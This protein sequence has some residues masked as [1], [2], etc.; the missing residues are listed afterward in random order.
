MAAGFVLSKMQTA[1]QIS[2]APTF[3]GKASSFLDYEP[4]VILRNGS[5][6][7]PLDK[8]PTL[9]ISHMDPAARQVCLFSGGDTL[10]EGGDAMLVV[11]VLRDY[12]QPDAVDRVSAQAE[13]Y[14]SYVRT[15]QTIEKFLMEFGILR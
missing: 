15:D 5:T 7:F 11:Q 6:D 8:R 13:R 2:Y 10:M 12:F 9:L 1:T 4:R 3:G 14:Q